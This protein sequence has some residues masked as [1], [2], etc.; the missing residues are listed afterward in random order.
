MTTRF[1]TLA[2]GAVLFAPPAA[3]QNEPKPE[4][5]FFTLN[6]VVKEV[7]AGK[8]VNTRSFSMPVATTQGNQMLRAGGRIPISMGGTQFQ[9]YDIGVNIDC[10]A[11]REVGPNLMMNVSADISSIAPPPE[12]VP[13]QP[14]VRT[15]RWNSEVSVP[16][17]KPVI[18]FS[19]DDL[20]S[21]RTMQLEVT[22]TPIQ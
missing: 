19:S 18:I 7:E 3:P 15:N 16:L 4:P 8:T 21:K 6:F 9:F 10:R 2:L 14:T 12:S 17:K 1:I 5:K 13:N 22:A 11:V 20:A